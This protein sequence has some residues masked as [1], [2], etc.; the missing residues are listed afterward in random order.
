MRLFARMQNLL[1]GS[2]RPRAVVMDFPL[3][4]RDPTFP[5]ET[6]DQRRYEVH[7]ELTL[8]FTQPPR[9]ERYCGRA[10]WTLVGGNRNFWTVSTWEDLE[11]LPE[12]S[13]PCQGTMGI[14]R[15]VTG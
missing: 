13:A 10:F 8:D 2:T 3:Y 1:R 14:L 5:G 11:P 7:Y 9:I 12:P 6:T 4:V 15:A